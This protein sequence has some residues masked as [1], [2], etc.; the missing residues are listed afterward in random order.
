[1]TGFPAGRRGESGPARF[2]FDI[3][4]HLYTEEPG[5]AGREVVGWHRGFATEGRGM[6][7]QYR[8]AAEIDRLATDTAEKLRGRLSDL[9][10]ELHA[11]AASFYAKQPAQHA[12]MNGTT[13]PIVR[14]EIEVLRGGGTR[15]SDRP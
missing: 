12:V 10:L 5:R 9:R 13:L 3:R 8:R 2:A 14:N 11:G 6:T 4:S 1:V 7:E 15:R